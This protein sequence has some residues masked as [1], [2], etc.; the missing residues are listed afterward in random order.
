MSV[1]RS[2]QSPSALS[3]YKLKNA[4][5]SENYP[6]VSPFEYYS[7]IFPLESLEVKGD[8]SFRSS[9]PIFTFR[10]TTTEP[11]GVVRTFFRNEIVFRDTF[12]DALKKAYKSRFAICSMCSYSGRNRTASNAYKC[13]G[14]CIDLDG[15]GL[16]QLELLFA[17]I[18]SARYVPCPTYIV[19]SGRGLHV[20]YV[21]QTPV[22]LYPVYVA[23]LQ[24]MKREL[25][26]WVWNKETSSYPPEE[27]QFQGIYQGFRMVG[28]CTK[29]GGKNRT[30][31]LLRA[32]KTG[33]PVSLSYLNSFLPD[34][35]KLPQNFLEEDPSSWDYT[36]LFGHRSLAECKE[37]F[38]DWYERRIVQKLSPRRYVTPSGVYDWWYRQISDSANVKDGNRYHCI[39]VLYAFG[40]KCNID[41]EKVNA[42]AYS[43]LDFYDAMTKKSGNNFTA[44][45]IE[46]ASRF[47]DEKYLR[48]S[49]SEII[50]RTKIQMGSC[51]RNGQTQKD[52]L[53]EARAIRDIR[54]KRKGTK[55]TDNNGRPSKAEQI[56]A[57]REAHPSGRKID[58]ERE[59]GLSRHTVLKWWDE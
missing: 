24:R 38:P 37:L 29:L 45:D 44:S 32:F 3:V 8:T 1:S 40:I 42:D 30:S 10:V 17:W 41:I 21:F 7:S 50:R 52:H 16:Q 6:E 51:H 58:C 59:T 19:N 43:L 27:R 22:P 14:L 46:A 26:G 15:V 35:A 9:N 20:V 25:T 48:L 28:S 54:Q 31:Y 34:N 57:W 5:L 36:D 23:Y 13:H 12:T 2:K 49:K 56:R 39:S 53:E 33:K 11:N 4:Y 47:Y 18:H 55:W